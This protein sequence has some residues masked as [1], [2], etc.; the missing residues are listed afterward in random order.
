M[1][2][3]NGTMPEGSTWARNPVPRSGERSAGCLHLNSTDT[4]GLCL[5]FEPPCPQDCGGHPS[6]SDP[7]HQTDPGTYQGSCSGDWTGGQ[8]VDA[9]KVPATL[10]PG[11]YV[12][13]W[14]W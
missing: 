14:R 8:I 11:E 3:D 7:A 6:C 9:V 2:I 12:L 10:P 13:G 1:W 4:Q 5:S